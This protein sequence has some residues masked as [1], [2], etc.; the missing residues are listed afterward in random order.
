MPLRDIVLSSCTVKCSLFLIAVIF[1]R[2]PLEVKYSQLKNSIERGKDKVVLRTT[3]FFFSEFNISSEARGTW[4]LKF[5][6]EKGK[7]WYA[8]RTEK[9]QSFTAVSKQYSGKLS[10]LLMG[11]KGCICSEL[12]VQLFRIVINEKYMQWSSQNNFLC[13]WCR[14]GNTLPLWGSYF[15]WTFL[16]KSLSE[17]SRCHR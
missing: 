14:C 7:V 15:N 3:Q 13:F 1:T 8:F 12:F 10:Y 17:Q 16:D 4:Y 11:Y 6:S 9:F 2:K 5:S